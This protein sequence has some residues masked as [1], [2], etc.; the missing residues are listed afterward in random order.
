MRRLSSNPLKQRRFICWSCT[1]SFLHRK[2]GIEQCI[3]AERHRISEDGCYTPV[4]AARRKK[5]SSDAEAFV[6]RGEA[7]V[8]YV[9]VAQQP[10]NV[11]FPIF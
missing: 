5:A 7:I 6:R 1:S 3:E 8:G 10:R 4:N 11:T 2:Q 9:A